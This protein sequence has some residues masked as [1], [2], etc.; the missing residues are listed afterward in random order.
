[1]GLLGVPPAP[2]PLTT[3]AFRRVAALMK[4][5]GFKAC[6]NYAWWAN[7]VHIAEGNEWTQ[8][9]AQALKQDGKV[10]GQK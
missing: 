3:Y 5:D 2:F 6:A 1:M 8:L 4:F 7:S 10:S 9:L